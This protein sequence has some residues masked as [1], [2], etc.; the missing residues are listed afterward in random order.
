MALSALGPPRVSPLCLH[1]GLPAAAGGGG[2]CC[3]GCAAVHAL[4]H[5]ENLDAYYGLRGER[6]VPVSDPHPERRDRKWIDL[7]AERIH[8]E[9]AHARVTLDVQGLHCVGCV[10]LIDVVEHLIVQGCATFAFVTTAERSS[11]ADERLRAY[12]RGVRSIDRA[13]ANRVLP[14]DF[15]IAWGNEAATGFWTAI[16]HK[17]WCARTT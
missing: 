8:A 7:L 9:P 13:S 3:S 16:A 15:S 6:G 5:D 10:W 2:F 4:L 1:C 11:I 17:R 12:V 14:G